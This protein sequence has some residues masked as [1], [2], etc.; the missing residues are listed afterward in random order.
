MAKRRSN[1][2]G[3]LFKRTEGGP[4]IASWFN[5]AGRRKEKSTRTTDRKAAERIVSKHVADAALRREHVID[6]KLDAMTD[7]AARSLEAHLADYKAHLQAAHRDPKHIRT[8]LRAIRAIAA[9]AGWVSAG[10]MQGDAVNH[11]AAK[12]KTKRASA[13]TIQAHL[14]AAK[15]FTRWLARNDKLA[16]DPL[17]SVT[18]PNPETDRRRIR[19]ILLPDEWPWL[20]SATTAGPER[21]GMQAQDRSLLYGIAIQSGL[22]SS[23]LRSLTRGQLFLIGDGPFITCAAGD[24][25]NGKAARQYVKPDLARELRELVGRKAP[26]TPVFNLPPSEDVAAMLRE[27]LAAAR[28]LWLDSA[29]HDPAELERRQG[30]DF[31]TEKTHDGEVF[32]FHSLRHSCG[33]WLAMSG[34]H[35]KAVQSVMRHSSITLT[36][37][38]YGHLFPGQEADTVARFP[39]M[40]AGDRYSLKAT[41]TAGVRDTHPQQYPQ[42]LGHVS[43][44]SG[45]SQCD[46]NGEAGAITPDPKVLPFAVLCD[47]VRKDAAG[48]R[49][50]PRR[51]RTDDPLIK[52]QLLYQLS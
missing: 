26:Q 4:W 32:D 34:A 43:V 23:E 41:G 2:Q 20:R 22:R 29:K 46:G 52:S 47:D 38:T 39:D 14:Q 49:S 6:P 36:M 25:K 16:R 48:N 12:L 44:R 31:L 51:T 17:A 15:S 50:A 13:R 28:K 21:M 10:D 40:I 5:H 3:T 7:A 45:A 33:A 35:P 1:G 24:T 19:R 18:K 27:D 37:D 11:Y 9:A 30:S 8:T 42:Q